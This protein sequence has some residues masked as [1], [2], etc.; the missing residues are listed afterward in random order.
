VEDAMTQA[1]TKAQHITTDVRGKAEELQH[2]GQDVLDEQ[3]E[4]LSAAVE[5]GK[6][7]VRNSL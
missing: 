7:V 3:K 5:S 6:K 4:R 1:R 2:R